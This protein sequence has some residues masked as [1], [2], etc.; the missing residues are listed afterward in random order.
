M[1]YIDHSM[2]TKPYG[3]FCSNAY[4]DHPMATQPWG[5][6]CSMA[7][8]KVPYGHTAIGRSSMTYIEHNIAMEP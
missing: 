7:F 3:F 6:L 2:A 5:D 4:I 1:A 8:Y